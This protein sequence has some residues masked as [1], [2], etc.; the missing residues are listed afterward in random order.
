VRRAEARGLAVELA[1]VAEMWD[2]LAAGD[3]WSVSL[4]TAFRR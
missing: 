3:D 1:A 4:T 2:A